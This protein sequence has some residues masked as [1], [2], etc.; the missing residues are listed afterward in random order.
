MRSKFLLLSGI[1]G[2][3]VILAATAKSAAAQPSPEPSPKPTPAPKPVS[4][5]KPIVGLPPEVAKLISDAMASNDPAVIRAAAN[6]LADKYTLQAA[7]LLGLADR[8]EQE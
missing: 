3:V 6:Q 1:V 2:V 4:D 5:P 8:I 7:N